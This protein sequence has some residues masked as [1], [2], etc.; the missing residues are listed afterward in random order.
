MFA[1][2]IW[3]EWR[4]NLWKLAFCGAASVVFTGML[5]RMRI[6]PDQANC[7]IIS[8]IQMFAVPVVYAL[9]IFSGEMTNRTIHLLFKIPVARWKLFFSKYLVSVV[10]IVLI[11]L[12]T[13]LLMEF[14]AGG[15]ETPTGY[16]LGSNALMGG[17]ALVLFTCFCAFGC[18]SR[19][20]ATSLVAIFG[21]FI[22][23]GIVF[24]WANVCEVKWAIPFAPYSLIN[25][26][27]DVP[28]G[29]IMIGQILVFA[30]ALAVA[31]YRYVK[32][33]RYL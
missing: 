21:V 27:R 25:I 12:V 1:Q 8:L 20:E 4:E 16:L 18:Q 30:L 26:Y 2:L 17:A 24:F 5:F 11:F 9:D 32:I 3:K 31:C 22:G 6:I 33:R 29:M 10:G 19:S 28:P 23:W 13:G 7:Y 15:R 14:M